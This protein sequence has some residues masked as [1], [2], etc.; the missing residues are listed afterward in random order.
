MYDRF[1]VD[2]DLY[3]KPLRTE[4]ENIVKLNATG[5]LELINEPILK[6][7]NNNLLDL[8][9]III[10]SHAD[11]SGGKAV[12]IPLPSGFDGTFEFEMPI[13]NVL[14]GR[15]MLQWAGVN[16]LSG[17]YRLYINDSL[18]YTRV[19]YPSDEG[20]PLSL[21]S[22]FDSY[23]FGSLTLLDLP[24]YDNGEDPTLSST[25]NGWNINEFYVE[26]DPLDETEY[27]IKEFQEEL[28][29]KF[30]F[31]SASQLS[32]SVSMGIIIDYVELKKR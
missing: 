26:S 32:S 7:V 14:P 4:G 1:I 2:E 30:E 11:A 16:T 9:N 21:I 23:Q 12:Q 3:N 10:K 29:V 25:K 17:V 28:T 19:A 13:E 8:E 31:V 24:N 22:K 5:E 20:S 6:D 15:Y 27:Y 18:L